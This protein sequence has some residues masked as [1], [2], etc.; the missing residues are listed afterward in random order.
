M[1]YQAE[2]DAILAHMRAWIAAY[3]EHQHRSYGQTQRRER[4][5][6]CRKPS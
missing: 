3:V 6:Q 2:Y 5:R 1:K 4:E